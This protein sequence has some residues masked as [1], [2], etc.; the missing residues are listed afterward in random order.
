MI[1]TGSNFSTE[2]NVQFH[3]QLMTISL[4]HALSGSDARI[5]PDRLFTVARLAD[6]VAGFD[7]PVVSHHVDGQAAR[8]NGASLFIN[9]A[10]NLYSKINQPL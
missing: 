5:Q 4:L 1:A 8:R 10:R 2:Q 7:E 6:D 9:K 3:G